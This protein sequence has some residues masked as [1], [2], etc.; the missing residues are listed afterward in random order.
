M[1]KVLLTLVC[2]AFS[3]SILAAPCDSILTLLAPL[4]S[5]CPDANCIAMSV[6]LENRGEESCRLTGELQNPPYDMPFG[7][8]PIGH[9]RGFRR[10]GWDDLADFLWINYR[11]K[12][13]D[14]EIDNVSSFINTYNIN[15]FHLSYRSDSPGVLADSYNIPIH[16]S[17]IQYDPV[18][19]QEDGPDRDCGE[20]VN[21]VR[22][23]YDE[24][25]NVI[26]VD[27]TNVQVTCPPELSPS[28]ALDTDSTLVDDADS[29]EATGGGGACSLNPRA[30]LEQ[31]WFNFGGLVLIGLLLTGLRK[32]I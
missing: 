5:D 28:L 19:V 6:H 9:L 23:C 7:S 15:Y 31:G 14:F 30:I 18:I 8:T 13:E 2:L 17:E 26:C 16:F 4:Q 24:D 22:A 10:D 32:K 20:A 25:S 1:K 12:L 3:N 29:S 11:A 27:A 21:G